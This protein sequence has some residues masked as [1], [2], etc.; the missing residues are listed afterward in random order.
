MLTLEII[1]IALI[2]LTPFALLLLW[3]FQNE[4]ARSKNEADCCEKVHD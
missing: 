4:K 3:L 1:Q 2:T